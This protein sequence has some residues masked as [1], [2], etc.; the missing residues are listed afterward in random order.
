[1]ADANRM[2]CR[3]LRVVGVTSLSQTL[4]LRGVSTQAT[5]EAQGL[6]CCSAEVQVSLHNTWTTVK[7]WGCYTLSQESQE[8]APEQT[9]ACKLPDNGEKS[10]QKTAIRVLGSSSLKS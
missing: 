9:F 5:P 2:N 1:M 7:P 10:H 6:L 3:N 4:T 8:G